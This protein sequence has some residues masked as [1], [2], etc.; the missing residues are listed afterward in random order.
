MT[1]KEAYEKVGSY[2]ETNFEMGQDNWEDLHE[3]HR[4]EWEY[5]AS[6]MRDDV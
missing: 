4:A 3:I 5:I 1:G 6:L 2:M